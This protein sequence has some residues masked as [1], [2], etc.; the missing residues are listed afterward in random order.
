MAERIIDQWAGLNHK[1]IMRGLGSAVEDLPSWV[2]RSEFRRLNAYR[3]LAAYRLNASREFVEADSDDDR[4]DRREYGDADLFVRQVAAAV[5]GRGASLSVTGSNRP[6][7]EP[8]E[9]ASP[10]QVAEFQRVSAAFPQL[11]QRQAEISKWA[12]DEQWSLRINNAEEDAV[13]IGDTVYWLTFSARR[14]RVR[15]RVL[16][17]GFYFPVYAADGDADDYPS[18][19]HLAWEYEEEDGID[20]FTRR[21]EPV[22]WLR[23]ITYE[24]VQT[25]PRTVAYSEDPVTETCLMTDAR[26][27]LNDLRGDARDLDI[28]SAFITENDEGQ[29]ILELD[30]GIDFI[31]VV[32]LPN[33]GAT[34]GSPWGTSLLISV[35]QVLD[36]IQIADTDSS[37]AM[38]VAGGPPIAVAGTS[39]SETVE[40]YGPRTTWFLPTGGGASVLDTSKGLESLQKHVD[41][42]FKRASTNARVPEEVL[43]KTGAADVPSGLALALS[44]GPFEVMV[45]QARLVRRFKYGLL[46]KMVQRLHVARG[47]WQG[48]VYPAEV[49]FGSALPSDFNTLTEILGKLSGGKQL[50]SRATAL[51]ILSNAGLP[52][53]DVPT[54][55]DRVEGEDFESA[56]MLYRATR[57]PALAA[58]YLRRDLPVD[59]LMEQLS[60]YLQRE[61][62]IDEVEELF[63]QKRA[64]EDAQKVLDAQRASESMEKGRQGATVSDSAPQGGGNRS[65]QSGRSKERGSG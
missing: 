7:E 40:H 46:L 23:R 6:P 10:E 44:F 13:G 21:G 26:W 14:N 54:E 61:V 51:G 63:D 19:V 1:T 41:R 24:L 59:V 37:A 39:K 58:D 35:A 15:L 4:V 28:A 9:D 55:V 57:S 18:K 5:I 56:N 20:S 65:R 17:P 27:R 16:D 38:S 36:D 11:V 30:L 48:K 22:R 53:P 47:A 34:G 31:P 49:V 50:V 64:A 52:I 62:R 60:K 2:P 8:P 12:E 25:E 42:L 3:I 33:M 29:P 43:G 32:H 45:E